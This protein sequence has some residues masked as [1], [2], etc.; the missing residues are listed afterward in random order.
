MRPTIFIVCASVLALA[1][2]TPSPEPNPMVPPNVVAGTQARDA[3]EAARADVE[4]IQL[5]TGAR[6]VV[7]GYGLSP[8]VH[9]VH[10][11]AVGRCDA[12]GF[13]S[14]GD[15]W[16]PLGR[17]HGRENPAGQHLGDIP[18]LIVGEDGTGTLEAAINGA[19]IS[20]GANPILDSD[21]AALVIHRSPDD[22]MT[23]PSGNSGARVACGVIAEIGQEQI[24]Y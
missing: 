22:Y 4:L 15:H 20:G 2:C 1:A 16:N 10:I 21:G 8:G 12:P 5:D 24:D 18:N 14:A 3:T 11:H 7:E 19:Q 17:Q 13:E 6:V 9:G 23:D